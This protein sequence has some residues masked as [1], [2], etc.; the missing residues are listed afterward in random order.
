M[1]IMCMLIY[2]IICGIIM[3]ILCVCILEYMYGL[4]WVG[5]VC[6]YVCIYNVPPSAV[7]W[8]LGMALEVST[9]VHGFMAR[10]F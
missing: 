4:V 5:F 8:F 3:H 1:L 6:V 2:C 9:G 7:A 10:P